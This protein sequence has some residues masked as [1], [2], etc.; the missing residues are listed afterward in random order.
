MKLALHARIGQFRQLIGNALT[1]LRYG[2]GEGCS[3]SHEQC[4][5]YLQCIHIETTQNNEKASGGF[6]ST[7]AILPEGWVSERKKTSRA[8]LDAL[9]GSNDTAHDTKATL[10]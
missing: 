9:V 1:H 6:L 3:R 4:A 5:G 2:V 7:S 8:E 10:L